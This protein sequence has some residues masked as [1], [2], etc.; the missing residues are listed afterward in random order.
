MGADEFIKW[1][2][3]FN[4]THFGELRADRRNAELLAL[5]YNI[6]RPPRSP[7]KNS[8]HFMLYKVKRYEPTD[9]QLHDKMEAVFNGL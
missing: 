4:Q 5:M 2:A 1:K 7:A 9:E 8:D 3:Y 6:N